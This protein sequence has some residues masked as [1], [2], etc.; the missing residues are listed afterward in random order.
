[1]SRG[2]N[3]EQAMTYSG[4]WPF[5][6]I[7]SRAQ[8]AAYVLVMGPAGGFV[9]VFFF[10]FRSRAYGRARPRKTRGAAQALTVIASAVGPLLLAECVTKTGSY[11]A[12]FYLLTLIV[13]PLCRRKVS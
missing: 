12:M 4:R 2:L 5:R 1:M 11:A 8:V 13:S 3:Y 6:A 9:V 10:S 7:P